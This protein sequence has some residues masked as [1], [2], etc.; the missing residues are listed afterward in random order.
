MKINKIELYNLGPYEGYNVFDIAEQESKGHVIVIGG[1]NGA[2]KTT[3]FSSI[4]L[5]LYGHRKSGYESISPAYKRSIKTLVNDK[6]KAENNPKAY[7]SLDVSIFNGQDWDNYIITREWDLNSDYFEEYTVFKNGD[8]LDSDEVLD[9]DNF[10]LSLIPPEL[11]ELYFFDGEQIAD[12]FLEDKNNERI[13]TAILTICGYDTFDIILKNFKRISKNATSR[14]DSLSTYLQAEDNL[15]DA[16]INLKDCDA[17]LSEIQSELE[18]AETALR[19]LESKYIKSGGVTSEQ[20]NEKFLSLKAEERIREEKN[21]WLKNAANDIIPYIILHDSLENLLEQMDGERESERLNVLKESLS[22]IIPQALKNVGDCNPDFNTYLQELVRHE[23]IAEIGKETNETPI[24]LDLSNE[25]Y[26]QLASQVSKLLEY[27]KNEIIEVRN[28]IKDSINRSQKIRDEIDASHVEG[29]NSYLDEKNDII[30]HKAK[31]VEKQMVLVENRKSLAETLAKTQAEYNKQEKELEKQLKNESITNLTARSIVFMEA[32]QKRLL[33]S[34]IAKVE[35][36]FMQKMTQL[37]RKE[38]FIDAIHIDDDFIIH[39][40]KTVSLECKG[41]C[42]R[43]LQMTPARYEN[44]NGKI[45]VGDLLK[46]TECK[47]LEDFVDRYSSSDDKIDV[48]MEFNKEIMSKGE[49][50]VFIMA[51]YWAI[52]QLSNKEVPFV[53]DTPFARIDKIHR[54]NITRNFFKK[55]KGQVFIFSTDEEITKNHMQLFGDDLAAKFLIENTDN[56]KTIIKSDEYF[57]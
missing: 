30:G 39:V 52:M 15:H 43:I 38:R 11:F 12:Y 49:R 34:E 46:A 40:Y 53:I 17:E 24:Y 4:K 26:R 2:G 54:E 16:E 18:S 50:Q 27:S 21:T 6:A 33:E 48:L 23:L 10:L 14:D 25:E 45:H 20:W 22:T 3:L 1:K 57:A 37:M 55:L 44:E 32:L 7:V 8:T 29:V 31:L 42:E 35:N 19:S 28:E 56:S 36:L 41:I 13:K 5:C 51:L 47:S 9:F